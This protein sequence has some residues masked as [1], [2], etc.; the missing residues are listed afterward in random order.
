MRSWIAGA[1]LGAALLGVPPRPALCGEPAP[2]VEHTVEDVRGNVLIMR[3]GQSFALA[4]S[5]PVTGGRAEK[6]R[7]ALMKLVH[8]QQVRVT[9]LASK[10]EPREAEIELL[11]GRNV[12]SEAGKLY[13]V[14]ETTQTSDRARTPRAGSDA[15]T[16]A[17]P[18]PSPSPGTGSPAIVIG[19]P[20]QPIDIRQYVR[21][22][23]TTIFDFSSAFCPP[24]RQLIP[25]LSKFAASR[26]D[27]AAYIID[28][29]RPGVSG[30]DFQ[31]PVCLQYRPKSL[32]HV[33][34]YGPDG[35]LLSQGS[36]SPLRRMLQDSGF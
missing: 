16:R 3:T 36:P 21:P 15:P 28:V 29:N 34:I 23:K 1:L 24:C 4:R 33:V 26:G 5:I 32:P 13:A 8:G 27:V 14:F 10:R 7:A 35:T 6:A 22:G 9:V 25:R 2:T 31:S 11:D 12:T 17:T 19:T 18:S 20:G 30:I